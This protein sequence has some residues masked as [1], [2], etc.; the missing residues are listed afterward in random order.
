[1]TGLAGK[2]ETL[3]WLLMM[4]AIAAYMTMNYTGA[5]TYTSLSGVKK[6]MHWAVPMQIAAG[7]AGLGL[8]IASRC[9]HNV[10]A[11]R[12]EKMLKYLKDVTTLKLD[13]TEM[14][15]LCDVYGR[16]SACRFRA[17]RRESARGRPRCV[18]GMRR[19]RAKLP[20][21]SHCGAIRSRLRSGL[22]RGAL[23]AGGDCCSGSSGD[24]AR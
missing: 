5:S 3:A 2:L 15:R 12:S 24:C 16:L 22:I 9:V 1:M 23:G 6:E 17:P 8:W 13:L 11:P 7:V 18:H 14:H 21:R 10:S 19:V 20:G 4:P